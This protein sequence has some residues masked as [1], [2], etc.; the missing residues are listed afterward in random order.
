MSSGLFSLK[1]KVV[2]ITGATRGIGEGMAT[3]LAEA[4]A[5]IILVHRGSTDPSTIV[6]NLESIGSNVSTVEADL[7]SNE[8]VDT[9]LP[10]ALKKS[11]N[12]TVDVLI[13][14]AG[15]S[16][17]AKK[18]EDTEDFEWNK[19]LQVNLTS[20]FRLAK[21]FGKYWITEGKKGKII[22]TAS[23]NSFIGGK[24]VIPY[25]ASKGALH[26]LTQALSNEWASKGIN[27]NSIIPGY[28]IT[29]MAS[30]I[31][32]DEKKKQSSVEQNSSWKV[33]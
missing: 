12:S 16:F 8:E 15:M 5:D 1:G 7:S 32:D 21:D 28:I 31:V 30:G 3:G 22:N 9:I 29:D 24:Y 2:V 27:I 19:V 11:P 26:S 33:G 25:T 14:N 17:S 18:I 13:N 4:G 23:L 10:Q 6:K 20:A